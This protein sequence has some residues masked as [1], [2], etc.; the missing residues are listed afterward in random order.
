MRL[1]ALFLLPIAAAAADWPTY[2]R[3]AARSGISGEQLAFPLKEAWV[4]RSPHKPR[5]AW[6]GP[7]KRDLYNKHFGL[8]NRQTFDHAYHAIANSDWVFYGSSADDQLY[9][10]D[11]KTGRVRWTFFAEGPIRLAPTLHEGRLYFGSDD[12]HVYC[13]TTAGKLVWKTRIGPRDYRIAGN[14]R[15][16]SAWPVRTGVLID[17]GTAYAAGGMFPSEGVHICALEAGTGRVQWRSEQTD[18]TAQGNILLSAKHLYVP[19]GRASPVVY[20][21]ATGKRLRTLGGPGGTDATLS[22]DTL[23]VGPG[24]TG[25]LCLIPSGWNKVFAT[26]DGTHMIV[27]PERFLVHGLGEMRAI[28]HPN[29]L[30]WEAERQSVRVQINQLDGQIKNARRG[31]PVPKPLAALNIDLATLKA[32]LAVIEKELLA[33]ELWK[34]PSDYPDALILAGDTIFVGGKNV[35]AA[36]SV[37]NGVE[38]WRHAVKGRV[39]GMAVAHGRLLVSTDEGVIHCFRAGDAR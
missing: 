33:C 24:R 25:Q 18:L 22:G 35:V 20:D 27:T 2:L 28:N 11:A 39:F 32:R 26:L 3:D 36:F 1:V 5:P 10:L 29:F 12:G 4:H 19:A 16:I 21:R 6:R 9:C 37:G 8:H 17:N 34:R 15:I 38:A 31:K 23:V 7:A 13:V 14:G 30:K